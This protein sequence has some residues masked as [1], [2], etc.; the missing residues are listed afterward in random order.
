M[1]M[2]VETLPL[3]VDVAKAERVICQE[4]RVML[5]NERRGI[6]A[7]LSTCRG[8]RRGQC[9]LRIYQVKPFG[10]SRFRGVASNGRG[11]VVQ[12]HGVLRLGKEQPAF[13]QCTDGGTGEGERQQP[14]RRRGRDRARQHHERQ[15][16]AKT[17]DQHQAT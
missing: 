6:R 10:V 4:Q 3:G 1:V 11:A 5:P 2:A 7:F 12:R 13:D 9:R 14:H 8:R 16:Q 17:A 15:W